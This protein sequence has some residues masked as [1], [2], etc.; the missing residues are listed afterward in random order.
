MTSVPPP[1][2]PLAGRSL[3][4]FQRDRRVIVGQLNYGLEMF[5]QEISRDERGERKGGEEERNEKRLRKYPTVPTRKE[6]IKE[7]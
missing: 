6:L 7:K 2:H 1:H 3:K 4:W 5:G